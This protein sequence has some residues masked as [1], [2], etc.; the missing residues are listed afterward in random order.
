LGYR[1]K[2]INKLLKKMIWLFLKSYEWLIWTSK[3]K[4]M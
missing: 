2:E 3:E 1:G 4:K